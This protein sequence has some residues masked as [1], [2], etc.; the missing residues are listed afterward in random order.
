[1]KTFFIL[2]LSFNLYSQNIDYLK[3]QD[4]LY[5][6]LEESDADLNLK[7]DNIDFRVYG[8][9]FDNTYRFIDDQKR[10]ISFITFNSNQIPGKDNLEVKRKD[11]L[12]KNKDKIIDFYFIAKHGLGIVFID[13]LRGSKRKIVYVIDSKDIKQR[14]IVLKKTL[15]N[16][17]SFFID[18]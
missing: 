16:D 3:S 1:M 6:L 2:F 18:N 14:K 5:L 13:I 15:I 7:K 9:G 17:G 4:T 10:M 8:N 12:K 11:F